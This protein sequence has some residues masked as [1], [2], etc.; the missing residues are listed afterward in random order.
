[1]D[2]F[3]ETS[4]LTELA[5]I[6]CSAAREVGKLLGAR[7]SMSVLE[8]E[9]DVKSEGDFLADELIKEHLSKTGIP[10]MSEESKGIGEL[11]G[12]DGLNWI[13][14]PL[15]GTVNY[16]L[17]MPLSCVSI[18]LW[19]GD[20]PVLGV[21][22]DFCRS[23]LYVGGPSMASRCNGELLRVSDITEMKSAVVGT[24]FPSGRSYVREELD[25]F[26]ESVARY[27]KARL[28]GSA[29]LSMAWVARGWLDCYEERGIY[30]WDV[31][32]GIPLVLGAGGVSK[33]MEGSWEFPKGVALAAGRSELFAEMESCI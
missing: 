28:L 30:L 23:A 16:T 26:A 22:Y 2:W 10:I 19:K 32:A 14:D 20:E 5:E 4:R 21:V 33:W 17:G 29:A 7:E 9:H 12:I 24:G 18:A 27:R 1:M 6:G 25:R 3:R 8:L 31:A 11:G 15:D 13:V